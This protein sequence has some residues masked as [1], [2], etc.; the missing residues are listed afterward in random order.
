MQRWRRERDVSRRPTEEIVFGPIGPELG[1]EVSRCCAPCSYPLGCMVRLGTRSQV[2]AAALEATGDCKHNGFTHRFQYVRRVHGLIT[3]PVTLQRPK[4]K[5]LVQ[6]LAI[7]MYRLLREVA[8]GELRS[9][10]RPAT[11]ADF[12]D[13]QRGTIEIDD[14]RLTRKHLDAK[15][16]RYSNVKGGKCNMHE[17]WMG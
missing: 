11:F 6:K 9:T 1:A 4:S 13:K 5:A 17:D 7:K 14:T 10:Y 12:V 2:V 15:F 8:P 16:L 3:K